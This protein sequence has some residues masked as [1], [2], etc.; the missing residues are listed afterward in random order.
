MDIYKLTDFGTQEIIKGSRAD[1]GRKRNLRLVKSDWLS[2]VD[3]KI[4]AAKA[5]QASYGFDENAF[6][7]KYGLR[8]VQFGNWMKY[9]DRAD[10]FLALVEALA[11]LSFILGTDNIGW[12]NKLSIAIGARGH[13]EAK[14]HFEPYYNI[15]NLTKQKGGHSFAH[16]YGH[17]ID[18][19]GGEYYCKSARSY[20]ISYAHYTST[21]KENAG[22]NE[23][24]NLMNIVLDGVRSGERYTKLEKWSKSQGRFSYW[25][26]NTEI[27]ARTFAQ[28]VA[29]ECK[30]KKIIDTVLCEKVDTG[31]L[32]NISEKELEKLSPYIKK[33]VGHCVDFLKNG[34]PV[35]T[36]VKT[37][38]PFDKPAEPMKKAASKKAAGKQLNLFNK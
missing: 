1:Y 34:K 5:F 16:E 19:I 36:A 15:I 26:C 4:G 12:Y 6:L 14:G 3:N 29:L 18:Y 13:S 37:K 28:W 8:A 9:G 30:K 32:A 38:N 17:A 33:L 23:V 24:R 2:F 11:H 27:W 22:L 7:Q 10:H 31:S 25:C 21:V 20:S 35:P